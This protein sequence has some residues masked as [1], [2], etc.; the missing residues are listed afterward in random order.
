MRNR[1]IRLAIPVLGAMLAVLL[2]FTL[3]LWSSSRLLYQGDIANSDIT[4]LNYPAR[5]LLSKYLK[6][7]RLPVWNPYVGG[8]F[9]QLAEGQA[10]I[11]YPLNLLLFRVLNPTLGF[12]LSVVISLFMA[13]LFSYLLFRL[14]GFSVPASIFSATAFAFSG[15]VTAKLKF[16]YMTNS[17]CWIPLAIYGVEKSFLRKDF[18]HLGLIVLSLSMQLLAGAPQVVYITLSAVFFIFLWRYLPLLLGGGWLKRRQYKPALVP[19]LSLFLACLLSAALSAPQLLPN[20]KSIPV[21]TRSQWT[22]EWSM[23]SPLRPQDLPLFVSPFQHGNPARN[24]YDLHNAFYWENIGYC[25]VITLTLALA[26]LLFLRRRNRSLTMWVC[27]GTFS[28]LVAMGKNTPLAEFLWRYLPGFRLFRFWQRYLILT[29]LSLAFLGGMGFDLVLS[30]FRERSFSRSAI[31]SLILAIL[32]FELAFFAHNQYSTIDT[33]RMLH[34]NRTASW[35]EEN[36]PD[37]LNAP[38]RVECF[39]QKALWEQAVTQSHGW[40]GDKDPIYAFMESLCPNHNI[41]FGLESMV[42]SGEYGIYRHKFLEDFVYSPIIEEG[43]HAEILGT[44]LNILAMYGVRYLITPFQLEKEG[45]VE[46]ARWESEIRGVRIHVYEITDALPPARVVQRFRV[47]E[48]GESLSHQLIVEAFHD[49]EKIRDSVILEGLPRTSFGPRGPGDARI[50]RRDDRHIVV[51]ADSPGG[52]ILVLANTYYP[53][54]HV[55]VDGAER[56]LLRVN[57]SLMGVELEPGRHLVEFRYRP[58]SLY[59]G[60]AISAT[61]FILLVLLFIYFRSRGNLLSV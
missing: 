19:V 32:L 17:F 2:L 27:I 53:E 50:T 9:P 33:D 51:E 34:E 20:L 8:G 60:L 13:M 6:E 55:F 24:T 30:R 35:L 5:F 29:V 41:L 1:R 38:Q 28:F 21:S 7:G 58:D 10:G 40:L 26:A 11:L 57:F 42:Q 16:S 45:L 25:G 12:N 4:E 59:Y 37:D 49:M 39:G 47:Y 36:L 31:S 61:G 48:G 22:L 44:T 52:G 56:E 15:F 54:W 23:W 46:K 43:W 3:P 14:Y 18:A